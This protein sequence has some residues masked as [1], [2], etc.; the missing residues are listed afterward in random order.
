MPFLDDLLF[1]MDEA[2]ASD[3]HLVVDQPPKYRIDGEVVLAEG[4]EAFSKEDL[5]NYL[6]EL[7]ADDDQRDRY[8]ENL[9]FDF[10]YALGDK[11]RY[12]CNYFHQR[13][14]YGAVFRIIPTEILTL[15][16]LN[17]PDVLTKLTELRSGLVL[18]TGPTGSGKSTTL[19]AMVHHINTSSRRHILTIEDPIEFVHQNRE[20]V[21]N[22]R[23]VGEHSE[24]FGT[25]L[26]AV[27][28][29]DADVVLVGE[30]RDLETIAL[31]I[32]A[33]AMGTLVYGTLHTN[34]APK[35]IDR[36]IDVFPT[37]QQAQVRTLLSE[38]MRGIV[39]Q[40]LLKKKSGKGRVAVN[41]ILIG[42]GAVSNIIREGKI[43]QIV[44]VL[45]SGAREGMQS[46]D[47][48]LERLVKDDTISGEDAYLKANEKRRFEK[49]LPK[50][51]A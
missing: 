18:V 11:F 20:S 10:A 8:L 27:T 17:L 1:N 43:E 51:S 23:E 9:D 41:E 31:A 15:E 25:A 37:D 4:Y 36:I 40:Q 46:M 45:Q 29:Q 19:A 33:A 21:I 44:S 14:G 28:R 16:Q 26:R 30:M 42:S 24:S 12:R 38:S 39:A 32:S 3:L 50:Q 22:H 7:M 35:T 47:D 6:F 48:A 34:S 5:G 13:T 49:Y 2:G